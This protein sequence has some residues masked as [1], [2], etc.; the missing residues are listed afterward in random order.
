ML[1]SESIRWLIPVPRSHLGCQPSAGDSLS[2]PSGGFF[3]PHLTSMCT[4]VTTELIIKHR[5]F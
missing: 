4:F 2:I 3:P 1:E 5:A